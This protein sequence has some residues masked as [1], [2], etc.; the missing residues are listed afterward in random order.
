MTE[1]NNDGANEARSKPA[2]EARANSESNKARANSESNND[3]ANEAGANNPTSNNESNNARS[4]P[5]NK[6]RANK[7]PNKLPSRVGFGL[8]VRTVI[9]LYIAW[10]GVVISD[11]ISC[12]LANKSCDAQ[13]GEVKGVF[14]TVT[15]GLMGWVSDGPSNKGL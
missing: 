12:R 9:F 7:L 13:V 1:S 8:I 2:N 6:A 14:T 11:L 5:P 15:V 4:K 10:V 3:G